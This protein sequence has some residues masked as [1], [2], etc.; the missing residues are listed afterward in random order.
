ME[1]PMCE[2]CPYFVELD[3]EEVGVGQCR[4]YPPSVANHADLD[5][6]YWTRTESFWWC[7]EHPAFPAYLKSL[8]GDPPRQ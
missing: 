7:G 5:A 2:T 1:R 3:D 4:R 6:D 8:Q